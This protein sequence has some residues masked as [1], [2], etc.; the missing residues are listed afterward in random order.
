VTGELAP[1][2]FGPPAPGGAGGGGGGGGG[3]RLL[4]ARRQSPEG[5]GEHRGRRRAGRQR[6]G[7]IELAD[8]ITAG[9]GGRQVAGIAGSGGAEEERHALRLFRM[10]RGHRPQLPAGH[11]PGDR[12][13]VEGQRNARAG[14]TLSQVE[15]VAARVVAQAGIGGIVDQ[16]RR[17]QHG[18]GPGGEEELPGPVH[19]RVV[20]EKRHAGE[21]ARHQRPRNLAPQR[22]VGNAGRVH[23]GPQHHHRRRPPHRRQVR[24]GHLHLL[25]GQLAGEPVDAQDRHPVGQRGAAAG[26][27][28]RKKGQ[29]AAHGR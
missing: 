16:H 4:S 23:G 25:P 18:L 24:A 20:S 22:A 13:G 19:R 7:E 1:R 26:R 28:E 12:A 15:D 9:L 6:A 3:G 10:R 17:G 5:G 21:R 27:C 29:E 14:G 8:G 2:L 11:L